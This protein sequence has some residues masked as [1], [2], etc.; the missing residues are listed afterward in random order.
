[1]TEPYP[2]GKP[3]CYE[4]RR[5]GAAPVPVTPC[6]PAP[7]MHQFQSGAKSSELKP[8]YSLIPLEALQA[9]ALR[10]RLG[11][12]HYGPNN[13]RNGLSDPGFL[14]DRLNHAIEHLMLWANGD[15][16][17]DHL[18]AVMCNLSMLVTARDRKPEG[19]PTP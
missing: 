14:G 10:F 2:D 7:S 15:R 8:D 1:M 3:F 17:D 12:D 16:S 9:L 11:A 6:A 19:G 18:G 5:K 4:C 13:W